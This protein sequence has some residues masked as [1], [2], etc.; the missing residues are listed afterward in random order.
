[1]KNL[2]N[3]LA[4]VLSSFGVVLLAV[5][6]IFFAQTIFQKTQNLVKAFATSTPQYYVDC[7]SGKDTNNG[8]SSSSAWKTLDAVRNHTFQPGDV[9][10]LI[11]GCSWDAGYQNGILSQ[12]QGLIF[13]NSGTQSA[14]IIVTDYGS[15]TLPQITNSFNKIPYV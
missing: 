14:P 7:N 15:G 3:F 10:Q 9:I 13:K 4:Q 8:L 5:V 1:M 11:R 12:N 2:Q 6:T